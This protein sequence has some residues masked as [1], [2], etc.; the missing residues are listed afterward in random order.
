[1]GKIKAWYRSVPIWLAFFLFALAG[2]AVS[3][4]FA[5]QVTGFTYFRMVRLKAE[6]GYL[7]YEKSS[8]EPQETGAYVDV[9]ASVEG[10]PSVELRTFA[11]EPVDYYYSFWNPG[12]LDLTLSPREQME[13]KIQLILSKYLPFLLYSVGLLCAALLFWY[14]KL[15]KPLKMLEAASARIAENELDFSLDYQ[16]RD[17]IAR[18]CSAFERMRGALDEN[19]RRMLRMIDEQHQLNDAYT[20]DL[21]T[22]IAVLKGYTDMLVRYVPTGDMAEGEVLD[23]VRTMSNQVTRLEKFVNSMNTAQKLT[24]VEICREDVDPEKLAGDIRETAGI[25]SR[26]GAVQVEVETELEGGPLPLDPAVVGQVFENLLNNAL[27]FAKSKITVELSRENAALTLRVA[28]DGPGFTD[29]ELV[30]AVKPYYTGRSRDRKEHFGLGLHICRTLCEKHGGNLTLAN[31][32][33]GG[34][35]VTARFGF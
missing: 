32:D 26:D 29:K 4:F 34:G 22:P 11:V 14:T 12:D 2:L 21:R 30:A 19:N 25:V 16:G 9:E 24:D 15:R 23:T 7:S 35:C 17:E 1:M 6:T 10:E 31:A 13:Y 18:L 33:P 28:D 5:N 20:H 3:A 27:R 8:E